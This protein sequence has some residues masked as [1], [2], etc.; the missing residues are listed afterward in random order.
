MEQGSRT[1]DRSQRK[2]LDW[3]RFWFAEL[4][5]FHKVHDSHKWVFTER[6]HRVASQQ[7]QV[8]GARMEAADDRE[9][10]DP[11]SKSVSAATGSA[12]RIHADQ[13]G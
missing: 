8:G 7:A 4:D 12:T 10:P 1:A 2:P 3:A 11:L 5:R 13:V 6:C 9:R